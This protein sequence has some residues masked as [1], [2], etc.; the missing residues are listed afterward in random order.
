MHGEEEASAAGEEEKRGKQL[1]GL[2][3]QLEGLHLLSDLQGQ[4]S[5][6]HAREEEGREEEED[7]SQEEKRRT[8]TWGESLVH[9]A[10]L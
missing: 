3:V 6:V 5:Q 9:D 8:Q 7:G 2:R 4:P 10:Y 1:Q